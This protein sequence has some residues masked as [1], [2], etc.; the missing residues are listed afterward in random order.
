MSRDN[1]G[2]AFDSCWMVWYRGGFLTDSPGEWRAAHWTAS[3]TRA[4]AIRE[5]SFVPP[6]QWRKY[7]RRGE[8]K[9]VRTMLSTATQLELS[10]HF[11][12]RENGDE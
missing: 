6:G 11:K 4:G 12:A 3:D 5:A 10:K 7:R 2:L 8:V 9:V 1:G